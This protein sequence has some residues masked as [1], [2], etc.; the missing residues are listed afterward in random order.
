MQALQKKTYTT[1]AEM[2]EKNRDS[3]AAALPKHLTVERLTR[4]ALGELRTTP[5]LLECQPASL[6]NAIVKASQL[7]LE[8]GSGMG[9]AY[10][11]PYKTEC[12]LII[13]YRGM[14]ALAR[15]SGEITSINAR[16]VYA[17]DDFM[18]EYGLEERLRHIPS[19]AEDPGAV[20]HVYAVAKLKDGGI[21]YEVMTRAEV[22]AI[23]KRSKAGNAGPW[24]TD[25]NEMA[26]KTV[27]R[28]LF[29]YLPMSIE[30][31]DAMS[32]ET[33]GDLPAERNITPTADLNAQLAHSVEQASA[34]AA[35]EPEVE[36]EV[37]TSREEGQSDQAAKQQ[38][39]VGA[40]NAES[41]NLNTG[42]KNESPRNHQDR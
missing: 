38:P 34:N 28:K 30:M 15:R 26:R 32:A 4:V 25:W 33:D 31:A 13:G 7:G 19:T 36:R 22:E 12:Q 37:A 20:T 21:Q 14:I 1:V 6:M 9:H 35:L 10:L 18:L 5:K 16:V 23:R 11:V 2:M 42:E 27:M 41:A 3:I 40:A 24:V 8:V 29:K 39:D 17:N